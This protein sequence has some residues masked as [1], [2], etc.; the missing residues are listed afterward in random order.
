MSTIDL[1]VQG[2]SCGSC[3]KHVTQAL[4]A[5]TGVSDVQVDLASGHVHVN[6]E[7]AQGS[8]PAIAALTAAGYPTQ[9]TGSP[10]ALSPPSKH[11]AGGGGRGC[12]CG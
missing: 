4:Q 7:F 3:V 9:L 12:C 11:R 8:V 2:M 5:L 1:E 10:E 6:G